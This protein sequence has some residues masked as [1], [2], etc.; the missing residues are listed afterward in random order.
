MKIFVRPVKTIDE[1][2]LFYWRN[3]PVTR[4][5]SF[6]TR[7]ISLNEHKRW[8]KKISKDKKILLL[9]GANE[10]GEKVGMVRFNLLRNDKAEIHVNVAPEKRGRGI[11]CI[12]LKKGCLYFF[13]RFTLVK[14]ILAKIKKDNVP[15]INVFTKAGFEIKKKD[16]IIEMVFKR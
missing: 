6:S 8:F 4:K 7:K 10:K 14:E 15:S 1:V 11:G 5:Y 9:V 3:D 13:R 2:D 16:K 12:L